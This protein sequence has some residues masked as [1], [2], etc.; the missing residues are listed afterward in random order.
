MKLHRFAIPTLAFMLA[1][2]AVAEPSDANAAFQEIKSLQG[3]WSGKAMGRDLKVSFR[4]TSGGS[5]VMSEIQSEADMVTMFHLDGDR[6]MMTHYC[7]SGNQPRMVGAASPDGKTITFNFIDGTNILSAQ[8]GH[9]QR[10]TLTILDP[11][12]HTEKWE[13]LDKDGKTEQH[14]VFDL[15]RQQ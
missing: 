1:A 7:D 3:T 2:T 10:L 14:E 9:M 8:M 5:A 6:V 15:H 11:N 4:V 13:F 12:H